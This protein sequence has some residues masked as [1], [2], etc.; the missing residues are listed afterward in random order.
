MNALLR[1]TNVHRVLI[2]RPDGVSWLACNCLEVYRAPSSHCVQIFDLYASPSGVEI[3]PKLLGVMEITGDN[4]VETIHP[5]TIG[6]VPFVSLRIGKPE[7]GPADLRIQMLPRDGDFV[8]I[9]RFFGKELPPAVTDLVRQLRTAQ[10]SLT[11]LEREV[12][13]Y[14]E[15]DD[16]RTNLEGLKHHCAKQVEELERALA[17]HGV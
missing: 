12:A 14:P 6:D 10:L 8:R 4:V 13:E 17:S 1:F 2:T 15:N 16:F 11:Y 5:L 3:D 7:A 9:D